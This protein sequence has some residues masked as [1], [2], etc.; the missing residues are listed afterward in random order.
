MNVADLARAMETIAPVRFAAPWDNVGLLVG[1]PTRVLA[2]V[3]LAID[4]THAVLSE[5]VL[6]GCG[7]IVAYHPPIFDAQKRFL[8]RSVAYDAARAGVA[9][10]SPHTALDVADGGTNDVLADALQMTDRAPLR[11][12]DLEGHGFGRIGPIPNTTV[13]D[14]I[15]RVKRALGVAHVL[16]AGSLDKEVARAAVCAGSGGDLVSDAISARADFLLTG[17]LRHHDALRA[18]EATMGVVC[19]LHSASE[20]GVLVRLQRMLVERC[21]GV[22]IVCSKEDREPFAFA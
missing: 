17:E 15:D 21:A 13:S 4:C 7:A 5:A 19:L 2:R 9:L 3:L 1:D 22:E 16:V 8:S 12:I 14:L 6:G 11:P 20:R 18:Q 10:Y